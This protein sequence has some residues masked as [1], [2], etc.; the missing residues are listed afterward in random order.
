MALSPLKLDTLA[1]VTASVPHVADA[2]A[3]GAA[4]CVAPVTSGLDALAVLTADSASSPTLHAPI[5][6]LSLQQR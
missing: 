3:V 6:Q 4:C 2:A 1:A 5:V